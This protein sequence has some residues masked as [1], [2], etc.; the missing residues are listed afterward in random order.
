MKNHDKL[1]ILPD[2]I[3]PA[4]K[5]LFGYR[6]MHAAL[7]YRKSLLVILEDFK[8]SPPQLTI[9]RILADST[10][11]SQAN[12]GKELGHDKVAMVRFIDGL[13]KLKYITRVAGNTDKREK[14]ID[15]TKLGKT[16]L[17]QIQ[18]KNVVR[19]EKFLSPLTKIEAQTLK[20][21]IMKL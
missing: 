12:L 3:H 15:L 5:E 13:E 16:T 4:L 20:K 6:L 7:K 1:P 9:M 11:L 2:D 21:L 19:E 17:S 10:L 18:K 8:I 14:L